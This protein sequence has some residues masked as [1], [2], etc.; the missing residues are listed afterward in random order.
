MSAIVTTDLAK[1]YD[2]VRA[3]DGVSVTLAEHRI[4]GLLGRNGAGKTTLMQLLTGQVFA[5]A[6]EMRVLG[7]SP[8]ENAEVLSQTAFIQESQRYP[9]TFRAVDVL[10]IAAGAYPHWDQ[11]YADTLVAQFQLPE[12]RMIKK[13]S[14]GQLSAIGIVIG[15]ASR[16]P[17]TFFD[18][19]YLGL[20]AV[21]R[22]MFYDRLLADFS[23]HP[24]TVVLSTHHIDEVANLLEHVVILDQGRVLLD[25][26]TDELHDAAITVSGRAADV[27][28]FL[29]GREALDRTQLGGLATATLSTRDG[30]ERA[31]REA[32]L[33]VSP[34]SLQELFVHLTTASATAPATA[35]AD[36]ATDVAT[37]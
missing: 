24:R 18:E 9:D 21:A 22:R 12:R 25:A 17:I 5:T 23:E 36:P 3:L 28:A 1:H 29:A 4:H 6:G 26:D 35:G 11:A 32:G 7:Q 30:D 16:A 15:L 14:R 31:A 2:D 19:P 13:L 27:D 34:V 37:V 10:R 20:D 8:V 33:D